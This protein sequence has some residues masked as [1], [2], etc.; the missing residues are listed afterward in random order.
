MIMEENK[1]IS[2][3]E[4]FN[5]I[6]NLKNTATLKELQDS[7]P[8]FIKL[9]DKYK[10][11]GQERALEKLCFVASTLSNQE[12]LI[13]LGINQFVYRDA[14]E[15]YIDHVA[16]NVAKIIELK[17]YI[18]EVPDEILEV[19]EKTKDIFDEFFVLFTDY[20]GKEERRVEKERREKDPILFGTF[21]NSNT[22]L[23]RFYFLGDWVDEYC[24]LTFDK[25]ID[26]YEKKLNK[27]F[28]LHEDII[29]KT[30]KE[31]NEILQSYVEDKNVTTLDNGT[32]LPVY[33]MTNNQVITNKS[34]Q[35]QEDKK[36]QSFF[37]KVRTLLKI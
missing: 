2:A 11:L 33:L 22:I 15:E 16:K 20:T 19:Y 7:Y 12:K 18:R 26:Q 8:L 3:S 30:S 24:D 13:E 14:I 32:S 23:D 4:Y 17:N 25:M 35:L 36:Q 10:T 1:V 5:R 31:L 9:A 29:P 21:K 37:S 27:D 6:K 28:P 34:E